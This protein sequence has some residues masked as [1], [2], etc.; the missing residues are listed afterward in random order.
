MKIKHLLENGYQYYN[1]CVN[2]SERE[3]ESDDGLVDMIDN[4]DEIGHHH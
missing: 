4:A 3:L 1:N 2:W